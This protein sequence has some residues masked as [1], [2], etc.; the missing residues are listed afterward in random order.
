MTGSMN[1]DMFGTNLQGSH[2]FSLKLPMKDTA[3]LLPSL[4]TTQTTADPTGAVKLVKGNV[5]CT[6]CHTPHVQAID[7]M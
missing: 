6:S 3:D 5:E 2:P 4:T 1:R 7:Q